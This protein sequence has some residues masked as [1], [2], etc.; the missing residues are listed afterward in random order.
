M[1]SD[2][3]GNPQQPDLNLTGATGQHI[4]RGMPVYDV[5]GDKVGTIRAWDQQSNSMIIHKGLFFP[6]DIAVPT[7][8]IARSNTDGVYLSVTKHDV[9][10]GNFGAASTR[11]TQSASTGTGP[12]TG[13][14]TRGTPGEDSAVPVREEELRARKLQ[15]E[16]GR[17]HPHGDVVEEQRTVSAPV[18]H[19][20][21]QVER[22]PVDR[23]AD[24][25][26]E[27]WQEKHVEA[28]LR[29]EELTAEKRPHISEEDHLEK[30]PVTDERQISGT[31]R[32]EQAHLDVDGEDRPIPPDATDQGEMYP[33][34]LG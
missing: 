31:V 17:D 2:P 13:M 1:Y 7:G 8:A 16:Q 14:R 34:Q 9:S 11:G 12:D 21:V 28:P 33:P 6:K 4:A 25:A 29:G 32:K 3:T 26:P 24:V 30:Q 15:E 22:Q 18:T 23:Q 20:E 5:H 19:E 27:D 10:N